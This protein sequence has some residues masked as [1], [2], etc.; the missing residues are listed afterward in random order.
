VPSQQEPL[1]RSPPAQEVEQVF[2]TGLQASP[3]G[4]SAL[5]L[6]PQ[7]WPG[8]AATQIFPLALAGAWAQS[9][10]DEPGEPQ[11][12]FA[13]PATQSPAAQQPALH[14]WAGLQLGEQWC[15]EES[16]AR[17][18][19][20]SGA[21]VHPQ[22]PPSPEARHCAPWLEPAQ[23]AHRP[24][25]LPQAAAVVPAWQ[26]PP[27]AAEQQP[28]LHGCAAEHEL[29]HVWPVGSQ[30]V[31]AG[32]SAAVLQPQAWPLM[33]AKPLELPRQEPQAR[34]LP[35]QAVGRLPAAQVPP[36][37]Q[38]VEQGW[39]GGEQLVVHSFFATSQADPAGQSPGLAQPQAPPPAVAWHTWPVDAE[40][41]LA[42]VPPVEPQAAVEVPARHW[43]AEQQ[44]P[45]QLV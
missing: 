24:P 38:P 6:Q 8:P 39:P 13:A 45:L 21:R 28:P 29:V 25:P 3:L 30:A 32:Q 1:Q 36:L 44:P 4:Q 37:Q 34:P 16:Q 7:A 5:V 42:Q 31:S 9:A 43:P 23:E 14:G 17:R 40:A 22:A 20:Q 12:S 2:V 11:A 10:H 41:Q 18:A 26:S 27:T 15:V 33:Q 35:P 19:G